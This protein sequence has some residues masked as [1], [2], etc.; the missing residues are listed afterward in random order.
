[1]SIIRFVRVYD[2]ATGPKVKRSGHIDTSIK[3]SYVDAC[4]VCSA[5]AT[6]EVKTDLHQNETAEY[7]E[8]EN[9][10]ALWKM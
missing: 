6:C 10:G 3:T 7:C 2:R 9:R 5:K 8:Y 1:V 4:N